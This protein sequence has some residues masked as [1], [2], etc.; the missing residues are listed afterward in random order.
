MKGFKKILGVAL[1]LILVCTV[2]ILKP[3]AC[4]LH[5]TDITIHKIKMTEFDNFTKSNDN[6]NADFINNIQNYF[7]DGAE[8]LAG[9]KFNYYEIGPKSVYAEESDAN[10]A[11]VP[12]KI[13]YE[14]SK[15]SDSGVTFVN[16]FVTTSTGYFIPQLAD[17]RYIFY[18]DSGNGLVKDSM[19]VPFVLNLPAA[20]T[21]G[22]GSIAYNE[23]G[24][25]KYLQA[26]HIYPKN[27]TEEPLP[28][29]Y[30][31]EIGNT[32]D[33]QEVG[34]DLHYI[35]TT[36]IPKRIAE[37]NEFNFVDTLEGTL[38]YD[39][40]SLTAK[41]NHN[42]IDTAL[43]KGTD[44]FDFLK[45]N[46]DYYVFQ[47]STTSGGTLT[48]KFTKS[49]L[50]KISEANND[51]NE[52][53]NGKLIVEY[54]AK[55]NETAKTLYTLSNE[56]GDEITNSF[57]IN[58]INTFNSDGNPGPETPAYSHEVYAYVGG[59]TFIKTNDYDMGN[60][61][62]KCLEGATF[63]LYYENGKPVT[64]TNELIAMNK[65]KGANETKFS[66]TIAFGEQIILKSGAGGTFEIEGL[67]AKTN[68]FDGN[69]KLE[70]EAA[71]EGYVKLNVPITFTVTKD[72][73]SIECPQQIKNAKKPAI[74][75]T[76]GIGA[77]IFLAAGLTLMGA[78]VFALKRK[79]H[80]E[81]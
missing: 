77:I 4:T 10:L 80:P 34:A 6:P 81:K 33:S 32:E 5:K 46:A 12:E 60:F 50:K 75:Q 68:N 64:W 63:A 51:S 61:L 9:V 73:Y 76:G 36:S 24:T 29:K 15:I 16:S 37:Y 17:G 48:V 14:A 56:K 39:S 78:A 52:D 67:K 26:M 72:G 62:Y 2:G 59:K 71:P 58:Y 38:N 54:N 13:I 40:G 31:R 44:A 65:A 22:D 79:E 55:I 28:E 74:P 25:V 7:G 3:N 45:S 18:E 30:I 11:A 23:D 57:C 19:A 49:G 35:L 66:G 21:N 70:E 1:T 47:P 20:R 27:I 69:Y 8:E 43:V 42:N 41:I 53:F